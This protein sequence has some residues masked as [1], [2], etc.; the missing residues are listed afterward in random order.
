MKAPELHLTVLMLDLTNPERFEL[1]RLTLQSLSQK[2][3]CDVLGSEESK[4]PI[5]V[6]LTFEGLKSH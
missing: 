1:A 6:N 4:D 3:R 2:I 5:P